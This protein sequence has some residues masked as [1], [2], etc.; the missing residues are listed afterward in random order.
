MFTKFEL[1]KIVNER[2]KTTLLY[3]SLINVVLLWINGRFIKPE[4]NLHGQLSSKKAELII[5]GWGSTTCIFVAKA[6][7]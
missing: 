7:Y 5:S 2:K 6:C 3:A 4:I 1:T